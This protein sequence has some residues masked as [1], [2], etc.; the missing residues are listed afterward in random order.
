MLLSHLKLFV[1][2][3]VLA[4]KNDDLLVRCEGAVSSFVC[5]APPTSKNEALTPPINGPE[6]TGAVSP[7]VRLRVRNEEC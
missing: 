1:N 2:V 6:Q 5:E 4:G 7:D 3:E